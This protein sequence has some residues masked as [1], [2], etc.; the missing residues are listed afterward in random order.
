MAEA[1][2]GEIRMFA[3]NYAPSGWAF[4]NGQTMPIQQYTALFSLLG[5]T[6]GGNGTT[7]FQV[8][9]L[10]SRLP[11]HWGQGAGLTNHVIG[12][13]GGQENVS[14]NASQM[15]A[16]TH[17]FAV[18]CSNVNGGAADPTGNCPAAQD[19]NNGPYNYNTAATGAM[20]PANT[21]IAGSSLP[22]P[23]E[24]PYLCVSFI[25]CLSG[26]YPSRN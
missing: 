10:R 4:C 24:S 15:P 6:Y 22:V 5:T 1:Y 17:T 18:P 3:G 25:I 8:P 14:L 9:D 16:H 2:L 13:T 7:T 26:I 11:M 19:P 21:G 12:Q 20:K 23:V